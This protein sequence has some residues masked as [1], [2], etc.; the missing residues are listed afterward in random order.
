MTENEK[1]SLRADILRVL[2]ADEPSST[3]ALPLPPGIAPGTF[4]PDIAEK[5]SDWYVS[6]ILKRDVSTW[7]AS[8]K[9]AVRLGIA[10]ALKEME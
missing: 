10:R 1:E 4:A 5:A 2:R 6:G 9:E 7:S 3:P 8:D